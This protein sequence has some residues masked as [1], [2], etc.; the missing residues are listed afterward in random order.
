MNNKKKIDEN[1]LTEIYPNENHIDAMIAKVQKSTL[2]Q[3]LISWYIWPISYAGPHW[4]RES[5]IC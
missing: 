2:I 5:H 4:V 1:I 3:S